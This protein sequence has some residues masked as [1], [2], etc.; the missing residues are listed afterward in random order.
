MAS[1]EAKAGGV[2]PADPLAGDETLHVVQGGNS[3]FASLGA[4]A[5]FLAGALPA[6]PP[7]ANVM[8][9]PRFTG[10][11]T[12]PIDVG[13]TL[14][15]TA[16]YDNAGK[17]GAWYIEDTALTD[18]D[19]AAHPRA[20]AKTANVPARYFRLSFEQRIL[21]QMLGA[22]ADDDGRLA[23]TPD[24]PA[25]QATMNYLATVMTAAG[26]GGYYAGSPPMYIEG[27][28][29][30][31]GVTLEP[32]HGTQWLG[33]GSA[34]FGPSGGAGTQMRW[35]D[36]CHGVIPQFPNTFGADGVDL[37]DPIHTG[38]PGFTAK[39][40]KF[41]GGYAGVLANEGL[42]H[43]MV[44]RTI[45]HFEDCY[46]YG[47]SGIGAR[48][49]AGNVTGHGSFSGNTSETVFFGCKFENN[50]IGRD[51]RG[52][53]ANVQTG[54]RCTYYQNRLAGYIDDNGA[55]SSTE[56]SPHCA[57]NGMLTNPN[58]WTQTSTAGYRYALKPAGNK[59]NAPSGSTA[60]TADW[61]FLEAGGA[62]ANLIPAY[63]PALDFRS[64]GDMI[65]LGS[66]GVIFIQPYS[67]Y[68]TMNFYNA[69]TR[70]EYGTLLTKYFR[71]TT[72][73][74]GVQIIPD[75]ENGIAIKRFGNNHLMLDTSGTEAGWQ[76]RDI[77]TGTI[78]AWVSAVRG[79]A[80]WMSSAAGIR[81]LIGGAIANQLT[82]IGLELGVGQK[83]T[84]NGTQVLAARQAGVPADA[85][86]LAT[87]LT[88]LN[89]IKAAL[90]THGAIGA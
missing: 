51:N 90:V 84:V 30:L 86:D 65:T 9:I 20:I 57:S 45:C 18:A 54:F 32:T 48:T 59:A 43:G 39:G 76:M 41:K 89:W 67:E 26:P 22:R 66:A 70:L 77:N 24:G 44:A 27:N 69:Y 88:L 19:V 50:Y 75:S 5:L 1:K 11:A 34:R 85:T 83:V 10:L 53:D 40:I 37:V 60:D 74:S 14:I 25:F 71:G 80:I 79:D 29:W 7:G 56:I 47:W 28:Y 3:R 64:G 12:T 81:N 58:Y 33:V 73:E 42:W 68:G 52:S 13:T 4:I 15:H 6:A 23:P 38:C 72:A 87:A 61:A 31:D 21:P 55:G 82:A 2:P 17:G 63:D 36:G 35:A 62:I 78:L 8:A 49:W 46:W 16:A